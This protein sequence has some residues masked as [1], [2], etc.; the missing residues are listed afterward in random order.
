MIYGQTGY[1]LG[2]PDLVNA[3]DLRNCPLSNCQSRDVADDDFAACLRAD[4][5]SRNE[6]G[7]ANALVSKL[8]PGLGELAAPP[9]R[10][11][12]L[13]EPNKRR[14]PFLSRQSGHMLRIHPSGEYL[15]TVPGTASVDRVHG[16]NGSC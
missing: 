8:Q 16:L 10:T 9:R 11:V 14:V 15:R 1:S 4:H 7:G 5:S 3:I 12:F 2:G 13:T 6:L